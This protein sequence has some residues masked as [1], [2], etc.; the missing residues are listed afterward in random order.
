MVKT[1]D[2]SWISATAMAMMIFFLGYGCSTY[3]GQKYE[4]INT[5]DKKLIHIEPSGIP[6]TLSRPEYT[7]TRNPPAEGQKLP[8]Y[9]LGVTYEPDP[10]QKYTLKID[11]G[12]FADPNFTVKLAAS[13]TMQST[14]AEF[15][16]QVTPMVTTL[17][18]FAASLI[19]LA[20][21]GVLDK[22]SLVSAIADP[23]KKIKECQD[24]FSDVP[25]LCIKD[26]TGPTCPSQKKLGS[27]IEERIR[28][29]RSDEKFVEF[30]HYI[31]E[32]ERECLEAERNYMSEKSEK[33]QISKLNEWQDECKKTPEE[34]REFAKQLNRAIDT[35]DNEKFKELEN[36]IESDKANNKITDEI[37]KTRRK[38]LETA[39]R[40]G[41]KPLKD[42][43][44]VKI[45][46]FIEMDNQTWSARHLLYLEREIEKMEIF[47][48][49]RPGLTPSQKAKVYNF[50][51]DL[52]RQHAE[53]MGVLELYVRSRTLAKFIENIKEKSVDRGRAPATSEYAMA[54]AE[55]DTALAQ[56]ELRRTRILSNGK[57]AT[58]SVAPSLK[59]INV[60][61]VVSEKDIKNLGADGPDFLLVLKEVE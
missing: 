10:G 7:V 60:K 18:S 4:T 23:L 34:N 22:T 20:A 49:R 44:Q 40:A 54:R 9:T 57:P 45:E 36:E 1:N 50:I 58:P 12:V 27:A 55:L 42:E 47:A 32:K 46:F 3:R 24:P 21:A 6:Y 41:I 15:A 43:A 33:T 26:L 14:S 8:T 37:E 39:K 30:F 35:N 51:G 48:L 31:T 53:T 52:R 61:R 19:G 38:L 16:E 13:G 25:A 28:A 17:G 2:T 29:F 59:S 5:M 56:I 11:P